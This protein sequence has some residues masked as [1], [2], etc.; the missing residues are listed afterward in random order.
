MG[1]K[2]GHPPPT[3]NTK[4][5]TKTKVPNIRYIFEMDNDSRISNMMV[6]GELSDD[7]QTVMQR[8]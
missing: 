7:A 1:N 4:T 5:K 8:R 6:V 2:G 3:K